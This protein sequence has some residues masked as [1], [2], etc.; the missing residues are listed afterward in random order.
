MPGC[1]EWGIE[2]HQDCDRAATNSYSTCTATRDAGFS[3][4]CTWWP[5]SWLCNAWVWVANIICVA[6]N[7]VVVVVCEVWTWVTTAVCVVLDI[8]DTILSA[9]VVVLEST[10]GWILSA[11]GAAIELVFTIP[12]VG[13]AI[14]SLLNLVT[15]V[16]SLYLSSIDTGLGILG[17][18]PEKKLRIC[19]VILRDEKGNSIAT[20]AFV[21]ARLQLAA[22]VFKRDANVRL[23]PNQPF[24]FT[25]GFLGAE[26]VD[27]SWLLFDRFNSDTTLLDAKCNVEGFVA[28]F[29]VPG[30]AFEHKMSGCCLFGAWRRIIGYGAPVACFIVRTVTS[31]DITPAGPTIM[32]HGG[33]ATWIV[34]YATIPGDIPKLVSGLSAIGHELGHACNLWHHCVDDDPTNLMADPG[35]CPV[36]STTPIDFGHPRLDNTQV[37]ALRASKHVTY[38]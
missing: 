21:K 9:V 13:A 34:D 25:T 19:T 12:V 27:D 4:C 33:C 38:F 37:L 26:M 16:S 1:I 31:T 17:V 36:L 32:T 15:H 7:F 8:L 6:W 11:L 20:A 10:L 29:G 24:K 3:S 2:R 28:D 30:A 5:C 22:D 35:S 23:V 14:R 18:R